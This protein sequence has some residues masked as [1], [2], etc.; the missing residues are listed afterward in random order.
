MDAQPA[1][2]RRR[3]GRAPGTLLV[4]PDD[5]ARIG[6][7]DGDDARVRSRAGEVVAPV[8]V[9]DEIMPGVV[10]LPH[11]WGHAGAG[12][13]MDVAGAQPGTNTNVL[14][15]EQFLDVPSGNAALNGVPVEVEPARVRE[16]VAAA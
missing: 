11:G 3:P 14:T 8:A 10:S 15:D 2:A 12:V 16:P 6:L 7:A 4:H 9:T 5:A 1:E 13:R